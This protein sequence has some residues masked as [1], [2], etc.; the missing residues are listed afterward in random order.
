MLTVQIV[1]KSW[2]RLLTQL[3]PIIIQDVVMKVNTLAI[4]IGVLYVNKDT[5]MIL[6][7]IVLDIGEE[8][9]D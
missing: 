6:L 2:M 9:N 8:N 4:F 1:I 7:T 5:L 3:I